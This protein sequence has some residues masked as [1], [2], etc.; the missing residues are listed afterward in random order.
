MDLEHRQPPRE[1]CLSPTSS[2]HPAGPELSL[3]KAISVLCPARRFG[4]HDDE[5]HRGGEG[6][7]GSGLLVTDGGRGGGRSAR[8]VGGCRSSSRSGDDLGGSGLEGRQWPGDRDP[9]PSGWDGDA[10]SRDA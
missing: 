5:S 2:C 9:G 8:G 1:H 10:N 7:G 3:Q 6:H 4:G